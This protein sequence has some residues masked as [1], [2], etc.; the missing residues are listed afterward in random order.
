[1]FLLSLDVLSLCP[2]QHHDLW[3]AGLVL[4]LVYT[5][6]KV[7]VTLSAHLQDAI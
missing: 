2:G 7:N 4:G 3:H 5:C 1:M 6:C